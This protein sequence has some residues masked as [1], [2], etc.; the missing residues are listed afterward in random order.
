MDK[1]TAERIVVELRDKI[2]KIGHE[3]IF[4]PLHNTI[5]EEALS[6]LLKLGYSKKHVRKSD[7]QNFD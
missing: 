6:A 1:K 3:N 5:K 4:I 7:R 2:G